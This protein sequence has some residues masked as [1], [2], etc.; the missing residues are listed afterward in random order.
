MYIAVI[1]PLIH[2]II[3]VVLGT[4]FPRSPVIYNAGL[5]DSTVLHEYR[6]CGAKLGYLSNTL[7]LYNSVVASGIASRW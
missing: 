7:G 2:S 5:A 1:E 3:C 4:G 6:V